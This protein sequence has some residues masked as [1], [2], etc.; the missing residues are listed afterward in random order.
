MPESFLLL[1]TGFTLNLEKVINFKLDSL[2]LEESIAVAVDSKGLRRDFKLI[3]G[4]TLR[5]S[6]VARGSDG[7]RVDL[8]GAT[9]AWR[10]GDR[11]LSKTEIT[12]TQADDITVGVAVNGE[13]ELLLTPVKTA[14]LEPDCYRH[15]LEVT[16][17]GGDVLPVLNGL[18]NLKKDLA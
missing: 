16:K 3:R 6:G 5:Y 12:I 11:D 8:T 4:A 17:P 15:Q 10:I 9:L 14:E 1:E 7:S 2:L 13:Y 18:F